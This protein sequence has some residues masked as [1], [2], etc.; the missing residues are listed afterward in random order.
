MSLKIKRKTM[1]ARIPHILLVDDEVLNL[2]ILSEYI[3]K[4]KYQ[5][6]TAVDGMDA[7]EMLATAPETYDVILLDRK[8]RV[9]SGM[10][11]LRRVKAHPILKYCPVILQ[12][13]FADKENEFE[14]MRLGAYG[15]LTKP[16]TEE[17]LLSIVDNA[18]QDRS[19]P[20]SH[21]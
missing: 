14:A 16:F 21:M 9:M 8:M 20:Q 18:I 7:W 1:T 4:E 19:Y 5:I 15:Y 3:P 11:V 17:Q 10:A 12:T 2:E 13:A 6:S